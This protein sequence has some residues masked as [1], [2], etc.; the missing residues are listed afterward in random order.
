MAVNILEAPIDLTD[1][2]NSRAPV[3]L[4]RLNA[5]LALYHTLPADHPLVAARADL[6]YAIAH[7]DGVD[8]AATRAA[9]V[10][11]TAVGGGM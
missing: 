6:A 3:L 11:I 2:T 8:A 9:G 10:L 7:G 1:E 4:A 5:I